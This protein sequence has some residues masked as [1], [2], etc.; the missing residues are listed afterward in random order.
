VDKPD[1]D[2]QELFDYTH[3]TIEEAVQRFVGYPNDDRTRE[4]LC[5]A[6]KGVLMR[7]M[8]DKGLLRTIP[9]IEVAQN[10]LKPEL[11]RL[12]LRHPDTDE[13]LAGSDLYKYLGLQRF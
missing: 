7:I 1:I 12:T 10:D 9:K 8:K 3:K 2:M 11:M 5:C 13:I 6:I 4:Q